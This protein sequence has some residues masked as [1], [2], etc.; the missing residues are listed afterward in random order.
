MGL[1]ATIVRL[2]STGRARL[3]PGRRCLILGGVVSMLGAGAIA[4]C[5]LAGGRLDRASAS[6]GPIAETSAAGNA[7]AAVPIEPVFSAAEFQAMERASSATIARD[8]ACSPE[9]TKTVPLTSNGSP[10]KTLTSILG[11]LRRPASR[12]DWS[13]RFEE[14]LP[15]AGPGGPVGAR[16]PTGVDAYV[17]AARRARTAFGV[18]FYILPAGDETGLRLTPVRCDPEQSRALARVLRGDT[19]SARARAVALQRQYLSWQRYEALDPEGIVLLTRNRKAVGDDGAASTAQIAQQGLL[20]P[21]A[22]APVRALISG[23]VPDGVASVTVRYRIGRP[24]NA[25]V[26]DNIFV[27]VPRHGAEGLASVVWRSASGSIFK[28]VPNAIF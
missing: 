8:R 10:D 15:G 16:A 24:V 11:A 9:S 18:T 22:G 19:S 12:A 2:A 20:D 27:A 6:L 26:I 25:T 3:R 17:H 7:Q 23:V 1:L 14:V 13:S 5:G 28:V 21:N 4:G